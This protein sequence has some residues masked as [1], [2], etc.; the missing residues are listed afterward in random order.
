MSSE[1]VF[2]LLPDE[3]LPQVFRWLPQSDVLETVPQVCRRWARE[4]TN[5]KRPI[6]LHVGKDWPVWERRQ[7]LLWKRV[8][9]ITI[10]ELT[11]WSALVCAVQGQR[12]VR[13]A[14]IN[15]TGLVKLAE[16][17][18]KLSFYRQAPFVTGGKALVE[19]VNGMMEKA[20]AAGM[21]IELS[22]DG[23]HGR[24]RPEE[25][26]RQEWMQ[27]D[28]VTWGTRWE[29]DPWAGYPA[30]HATIS[31]NG[32]LCTPIYLAATLPGL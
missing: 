18:K 14:K 7:A 6:V 13:E 4:A 21:R 12:G 16:N 27:Q 5:D 17:L 1:G 30:A 3:L 19:Q 8:Q 10:D 23:K 9:R 15:V 22:Y 26:L 20:V 25:S 2:D 31:R 11:D 24:C 32:D 29:Y 28:G